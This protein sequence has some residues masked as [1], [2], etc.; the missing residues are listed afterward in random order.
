MM[1]NRR[2][3]QDVSRCRGGEVRRL[4]GWFFFLD[5]PPDSYSL[6]GIPPNDVT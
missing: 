1:M 6:D 4:F 2:D 3:K 5:W